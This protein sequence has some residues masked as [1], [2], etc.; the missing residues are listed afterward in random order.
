MPSRPE[1]KDDLIG[2]AA[3]ALDVGLWVFDR[4]LRVGPIEIGTRMTVLR[5]EDGGLLLHSPV[6]LDARTR[7]ALDAV[8]RVSTAA[9]ELVALLENTA[10]ELPREGRAQNQAGGFRIHDHSL[11]LG[12]TRN[13]Y[14]LREPRGFCL[15]FEYE[16]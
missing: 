11:T 12:V 16:V 5:L 7:R 13:R 6:A 1:L 10:R 8:G 3:R 15:A 14:T 9:L 4:P 2:D